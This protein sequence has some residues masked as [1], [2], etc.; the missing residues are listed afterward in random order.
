M[1]KRLAVT[2]L[3]SYFHTRSGVLKAIDGVSFSINQGETLALV[4]ESGCGKSMTALSLL[5]LLPEPGRIVAGKIELDGQDLLQLSEEEMRKIRGNAISMIF[6]EP[7]TSL[8]PVLRIGEQIAEVLR[9]HRKMTKSE[10]LTQAAKLL[11]RVGIAD[12]TRRLRE[13]PHQ[14]SGGQRQR[15]M[16]AM[17][18]ACK[19]RLLI[20]D[21]PTTALDVTIQAQ[22]MDLLRQM[23]E[24]FQTTMLLIS[25]DLGVVAGNADK[26]AVMYAGKIV[27]YGP[28]K[29][30]FSNPAHPYTRGLLNC[31][32]RLGR[33]QD[34]PTIPG[35]LPNLKEQ[36][37]GCLFLA[38]CPQ[39]CLEC[40]TQAPKMEVLENDHWV[41]C[42]RK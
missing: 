33:K 27:E 16:I 6:Q 25:H 40:P 4:G 24:E 39:P 9:L 18:L 34:L 23:Q 10:A 42:W 31:V 22:I 17:A 14:L 13:Y 37:E 20:A 2:G 30:V 11:I 7:M 41:R 12:A 1:S 21:E 19:P 5:R 15:V 36:H 32:P 8:N 38:R 28:V 29:E 26:I 3:K 35:S